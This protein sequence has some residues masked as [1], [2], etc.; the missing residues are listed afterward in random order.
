MKGMIFR[1]FI[2]MVEDKF[3]L[4]VL[5]QIIL[6]SKL[7]NDGAY[8]STGT[9]DHEEMISMVKALSKLKGVPVENL[10]TTFGEHLFSRFTSMYPEYFRVRLT[11]FDFL[12]ILDNK[13]HVGVKK[14]YPDAEL[15]TFEHHLLNPNTFVFDYYSSRPFAG[16]AEGLIK[17][18]IN[19]FKESILLERTVI[20]DKDVTFTRFTLIKQTI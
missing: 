17:G 3:S 7:D 8:V 2:D 9:Y 16:V 4:E 12:S 10:L 1:E 6:E 18:C 13:V 11:C 19:H 20:N 14:L 15:P 5:D